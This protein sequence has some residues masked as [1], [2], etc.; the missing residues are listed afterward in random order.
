[1]ALCVG[2]AVVVPVML[3]SPASAAKP[4]GYAPLD[5][6]GPPLSVPDS[7]LRSSL[8]CTENLDSAE[9][10]PILFV[11]GT[12]FT[13]EEQYGWSYMRAFRSFGWPFCAVT[14]PAQA[15]GDMQIAGEYVVYALRTMFARTR[16]RVVILG[17]SQGGTLP[18]W[19]LRF[20]PD[21]RRMV[22]DQIGLGPPNHG[23]EA[24]RSY[25]TPSCVPALWQQLPEAR[26]IDALNSGLETFAGISYTAIYT[27]DDAVVTPPEEASSLRGGNGSVANVAL[28]DVCPGHRS[29]HVKTLSYDPV[30]FALVVDAVRHDGPAD[31]AR[32]DRAVC[33]DDY[34]PGVD[35][36][37]FPESYARVNARILR[38][39]TLG[40]R[41]EEEPPLRCYVTANCPSARR[42]LSLKIVGA[43]LARVR[44]Q[45]AIRVRVR[46]SEPAVVKLRATARGRTIAVR[47]TRLSGRR[48]RRLS[49]RLTRSGRR[50]VCRAR[51]LTVRVSAQ[52]V[53][54]GGGVVTRVA[55]RR[56][57]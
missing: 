9:R 8:S 5:A 25:C 3:A 14:T 10:D 32:I 15:T 50:S 35:P 13:P 33:D 43:R 24:V 4:A 45:R 17:G 12:T 42:V 38:E 6:P 28:Q 49:I 1:M 54:R 22:A 56:L 7:E 53:Y 30:G 2:V 55:K 11:P 21:T 44:R 34:P 41:S 39:L 46:S 57:R 37:T 36:V 20:W 26:F 19:A 51:R 23:S 52:A 47:R 18:R 40:K 29:D 31:P 27:R 48:L 16:R